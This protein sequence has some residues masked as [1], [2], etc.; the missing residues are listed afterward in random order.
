MPG[1]FADGGGG[2]GGPQR[3]VGG[4]EGHRLVRRQVGA[5]VGEVPDDA[6]ESEEQRKIGHEGM[7]AEEGTGWPARTGEDR[8]SA[9]TGPARRGV[10]PGE[11]AGGPALPGLFAVHRASARW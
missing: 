5:D 6:G 9:G 1:G 4:V 3:R 8:V 10:A 2:H 11:Q 7:Q